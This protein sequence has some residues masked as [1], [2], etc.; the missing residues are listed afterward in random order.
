MDIIIDI[1]GYTEIYGYLRT[2]TLISV[3][4]QIKTGINTDVYGY[5][6]I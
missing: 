5:A 3:E 2:L 4:K 6:D 1:C